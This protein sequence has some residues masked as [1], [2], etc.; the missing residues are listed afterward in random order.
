MKL[1]I[2]GGAGF[3]GSNFIFY[4][5]RT[6]PEYELV[7]IDA[8]TYA[9]NPETLK[10]A[11]G[12]LRFIQ[13]DISDKDAINSLFEQEHFDCVVNFAAESHVD[14]SIEQPEIFLTTNIMG[15]QVLMDACRRY[16]VGRFHQVSTD[17]VY[18]DL[19]LDKTELSF[20]ENSPIRASSP[21]SASKAA[22]DLLALAYYRTYGLSVTISRC[23]N[24]FGPFQFPEKLIP[25]TI[26]NALQGKRIP[27]YGNGQNR[28][29]WIF[30]EDHCVAIDLI[31]EKGSAGETYNIGS[32]SERSNLEVVHSILSVLGKSKDLISFVADRPGHDLRYSINARKTQTQLGWIPKT[33][34]SDG[35]RK[36]VDWYIKNKS[37]WEN[38]LN[39]TYIK[40]TALLSE[41]PFQLRL[42]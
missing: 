2:T 31:L 33:E 17:E 7:C 35:L 29:D 3:I 22:A 6:H 16:K 5:Q 9:G 26:I 41:D 24:N 11:L 15:T 39:G 36:T 37:W 38:I 4:M 28:R 19:P 27:V 13:M 32:T 14:R 10:K 12:K 30:V 40:N 42:F 20:D 34:F 23:S 1:L 21:Y 25:L 8:L 18:G